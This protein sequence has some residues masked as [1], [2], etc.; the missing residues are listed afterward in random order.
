[1]DLALA[2]LPD[3]SSPALRGRGKRRAFTRTREL[4]RTMQ[5]SA[6]TTEQRRNNVVEIF[7]AVAK[8]LMEQIRPFP[9]MMRW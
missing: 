4:V 6:L 5:A 2:Q 1:M 7:P 8:K 9:T 3:E